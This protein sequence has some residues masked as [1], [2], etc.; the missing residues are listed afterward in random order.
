MTI[1]VSRRKL[2]LTKIHRFAALL[3][4]VSHPL[5]IVGWNAASESNQ[6]GSGYPLRLNFDQFARKF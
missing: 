5:E 2:P 6:F 4:C 3:D 1:F